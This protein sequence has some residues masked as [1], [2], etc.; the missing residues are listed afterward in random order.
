MTF[1]PRSRT[2]GGVTRIVRDNYTKTWWQKTKDIATRDNGCVQ[3]RLE[4]KVSSGSLHTHHIKPLSRGGT[5]TK[6]N[7]LQL[8]EKHHQMRHSHSVK[9][10]SR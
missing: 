6:A 4:G 1:R 7:M 2:I 8:C 5:T 9:K 3:C 10:G